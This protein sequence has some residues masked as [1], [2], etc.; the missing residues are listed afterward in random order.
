M[1]DYSGV[2]P[3]N[4]AV[5]SLLDRVKRYNKRDRQVRTLGDKLQK[6]AEVLNSLP[7]AITADLQLVVDHCY[8]SCQEFERSL[9][10]FK[11][12]NKGLLDL[13]K[14]KFREGN[15]YLF[16]D[17]IE[18][19]TSTI[20]VYLLEYD[21]IKSL[22]LAVQIEKIKDT[23]HDLEV[24]LRQIETHLTKSPNTALKK[25]LEEE[26]QVTW[27]CLYICTQKLSLLQVGFERVESLSARPYQAFCIEKAVVTDGSNQVVVACGN[28]QL[29]AGTAQSTGN[30]RQL[31]G[32]TTPDVLRTLSE[33]HYED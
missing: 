4:N 10:D 29:N 2:P 13:S 7:E 23:R 21:A 22:S 18:T 15:I 8:K 9:E 12:P 27:I 26:C 20:L 17:V 1:A 11:G 19:Y 16:I 32:T 31:V 6:L 14:P 3:S 30:S 25:K 24:R 33:Q 28:S 5:Q